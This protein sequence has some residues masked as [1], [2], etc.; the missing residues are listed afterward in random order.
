VEADFT[1][2]TSPEKCML[3]P[4][5][6]QLF[7]ENIAGKKLGVIKTVALACSKFKAGL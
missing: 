5:R 6:L 3:S 7:K 2:T 1:G 4:E